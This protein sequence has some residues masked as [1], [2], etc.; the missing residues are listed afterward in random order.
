ML[1]CGGWG[2]VET[3][4]G[5]TF[6][7]VDNDA[8]VRVASDK[9]GDAAISL[10]VEPGPGVGGPFLLKVLDPSGRQVASALV[11]RRETIDL[12]VPV[13]AAKTNE[14]RLHVTGGGRKTPNDPR[15]LN[16]RVFRIGA[17]PVPVSAR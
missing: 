11:N 10:K 2:G 5:E 17:E 9:S 3:F 4:Q 7:W 12:F 1:S 15:I 13:E 16:F 6:R 14:F 8:Q